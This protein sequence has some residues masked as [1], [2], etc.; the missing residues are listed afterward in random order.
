MN[1]QSNQQ[2]H[3]LHAI[4]SELSA[5]L[6]QAQALSEISI[7]HNEG[8]NPGES[9]VDQYARHAKDLVESLRQTLYRL[10]A[11]NT[12]ARLQALES[13]QATTLSLKQNSESLVPQRDSAAQTHL[14]DS[15]SLDL[16]RMLAGSEGIT[17]QGFPTATGTHDLLV[18]A[19]HHC[20][21]AE[22]KQI[23]S[24]V[25]QF[26]ALAELCLETLYVEGD[27]VSK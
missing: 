15:I 21:Q 6:C 1:R 17:S 20:Y 23:R 24:F 4:D 5:L 26:Q 2:N 27:S 11:L 7:E 9:Q 22:T 19:H 16:S 13:F 14:D 10:P 3:R 25:A 18:E 12:E 8:A